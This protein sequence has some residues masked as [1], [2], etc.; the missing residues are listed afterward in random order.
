MVERP[1]LSMSP[2]CVGFALPESVWP[3]ARG[4]ASIAS[5]IAPACIAPRL[6]KGGTPRKSANLDLEPVE[7]AV[8]RYT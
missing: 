1:W 6:V 5:P 3:K 4:A 7:R 8:P 2:S